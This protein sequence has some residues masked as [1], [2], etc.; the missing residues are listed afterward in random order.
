[1]KRTTIIRFVFAAVA[2]VTAMP[3]IADTY[4]AN[5]ITWTYTVSNGGATIYNQNYTAAIPTSTS[6]AIT[7]PSDEYWS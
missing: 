2:I 5:G 4:T 3:L 1:M 6:G 7:I